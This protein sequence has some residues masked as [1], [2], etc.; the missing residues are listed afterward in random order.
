MSS[1]TDLSPNPKLSMIVK[2]L[3]KDASNATIST[4]EQQIFRP[5]LPIQ[6]K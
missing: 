4:L 3:E 6:A 5:A 2:K 1:L